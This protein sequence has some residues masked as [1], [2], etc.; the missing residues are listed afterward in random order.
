[1]ET[2]ILNNGVEIPVIGLGTFPMKRFELLKTVVTSTKYNYISFDTSS[3]YGNERALGYALKVC[4]KKREEIFIT[5]KLSNTQ[6][7]QGDVRKALM[8]SLKHL[9]TKY[10]DMYLMH[11]P[12]PETFIESWKQMEELYEEGL[13]RAIGVCNFHEHHIEDLLAV[14]NVIP[15]VNQIELHPLLSQ[16]P[17]REYCNSKGILVEAY[18]P[19]A[20]MNEKLVKNPTMMALAEKY[21]KSVVQIILKWNLQSGIITI[22]KTSNKERLKANI[23]IFDFIISDKDMEAI[24]A[25]NQD[26]RVRHD[27]DN[28]DFSK[29]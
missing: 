24:D 1:M 8:D 7:R 19:L 17:L 28:C 18:S 2:F 27:P 22:P 16:K 3:A 13:C 5:T 23:N 11:W 20:R 21:N 26:Y 25:I 15:A 29:L 12:N 6:Q 4:G 14:A 9:K 10:V